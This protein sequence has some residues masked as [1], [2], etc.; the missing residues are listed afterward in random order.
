MIRARTVIVGLATVGMFLAGCGE[1]SPDTWRGTAAANWSV[2][3]SPER[4]NDPDP[5]RPAAA[6]TRL[7]GD[8]GLPELLRYAALN[9]PGLASAFS[10][11]KAAVERVPQVKALPDPRF[12]YRYFIEEVETRVGSQRQSFGIAQTFPWF[13]KLSLRGDAASEAAKAEYQRYEAVKL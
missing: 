12:T 11:W 7:K 13:G 2:D 10:R 6:P 9:N 1:S 4:G 3:D 5:G 8:A